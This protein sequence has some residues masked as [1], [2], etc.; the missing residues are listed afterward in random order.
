MTTAEKVKSIEQAQN[1]ISRKLGV[2]ID[3]LLSIILEALKYN[4][5]TYK[6]WADMATWCEK[7]DTP[8]PYR[9]LTVYLKTTNLRV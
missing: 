6:N 8:I 9:L 3:D 5:L 1:T 2:S 4:T 7:F